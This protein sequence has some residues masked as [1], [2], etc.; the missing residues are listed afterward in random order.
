MNPMYVLAPNYMGANFENSGVDSLIVNI[1][2]GTDSYANPALM[3][4]QEEGNTKIRR[5]KAREFGRP[6]SNIG[7]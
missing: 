4:K 6:M 2:L 1:G 3:P 7:F 5:A